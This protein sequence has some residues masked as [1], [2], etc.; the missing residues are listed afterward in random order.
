VSDYEERNVIFIYSP[1]NAT[2][3]SALLR[4]AAETA[5]RQYRESDGWQGPFVSMEP[6]PPPAP[7][8]WRVYV[9]RDAASKI[10]AL[11]AIG[12]DKG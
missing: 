3:L 6:P 2:G 8:G 12:E 10:R 5:A 7:A 11:P 4:T 9:C 1:C